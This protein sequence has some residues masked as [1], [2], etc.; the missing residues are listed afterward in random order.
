MMIDELLFSWKQCV[1]RLLEEANGEKEAQH[2]CC[3]S[4]E[5]RGPGRRGL[6][7]RGVSG[8][9]LG[10]EANGSELRGDSVREQAA[11]D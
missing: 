9:R 11:D 1:R 2:L 7:G 8:E 3:D 5:E 10:A 4:Y 6:K